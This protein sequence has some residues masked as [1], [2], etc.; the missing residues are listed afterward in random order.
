MN[1]SNLRSTLNSIIGKQAFLKL[2]LIASLAISGLSQAADYPPNIDYGQQGDFV[3]KRGEQ[4]GRTAILMPIGPIMI[5]LPEL[6]GSSLVNVEGANDLIDVARDSAWDLSDL[7]NPQLIRELREPRQVASMPIHAHATVI[8]VDEQRGPLL[9]GR[10]AGDLQFDPSGADSNSQLVRV[11]DFWRWNRTQPIYDPISYTHLTAPYYVRNYW[12]YDLD[13]SGAMAIRDTSRIVADFPA[14]GVLGVSQ[15]HGW[16]GEVLTHWD[17]LGTTSVTG[18]TTW[19]GNLVVVTSD[20]LS[21]GMAIYDVSGFKEGREP[22]LLSVYQPTLSE[23]DGNGG[24]NQIGIGGYWV[25]SYGANK[26]VFSARARDAGPRR[27]NPGMFIVDFTDPTNPQLSCELYFDVDKTDQ[28]DGDGSSDPMYVNFQD[29]YAYVDHFKVD[30]QACESAYVDKHISDA[31]FKQIVYKFDDIA[32][33]CDSS[34]YFRPLGQVGLFGGYDWWQTDDVNEQGMCFF[35]TDDEPDTNAPYVAGHRPLAGQS[36]YPIDGL[37]QIHIPETLRSETLNNAVQLTIAE[38]GEAVNFRLQLSHTGILGVWPDEYLEPNTEYR[39]QV[40]G[41]AD[42]MGNVMTPY[43]F[44]FTTDNGDLFKPTPGA[45]GGAPREV[46]PSYSGVPYFPNQS[47]QMACQPEAENKDLWVVNPDNDS[48]AIF[49]TSLDPNDYSKTHQ[50]RREV[51]LNFEK[52]TSVSKVAGLFAVTHADDDK[53]VFYN[54]DGYPRFTIDTGHGSHPIAS[55]ADG[56]NLYVALYGSGEVAKLHVGRREISQRITVGPTP[57][58]MALFADR[59]LVTRFISTM[60]H[61]EVYDIE[62]GDDMQLSQTIT[63]NKVLV[64]DD[65]VNGSG[66]P[67]YLSSIVINQDGT[68]AWITANKANVDRGLQRSGEP[69][70]EDNTIRP[71]IAILDLT[72]GADANIDPTTTEGSIDLDN[73]ADPSGITL[74]ANPQIQAHTLR[75]NNNLILTNHERNSSAQ[76]TTGSAPQEMC[77]TLRTLYVKNYTDRTVSAIDVASY[78]HSNN[79]TPTIET[80]STVTQEKLSDQELLGLQT[81]YFS[82]IPEMGREGYMT[83]ASCHADGGHDGMTWDITALGEG[84]RNTLSLNGSSGTRFGNLHWS[85]NFDEVQDFEIQM[86]Q[87]NGGDGLIPDITFT[88]GMSPLSHITSGQSEQLDALAAYVNG[89]GKDRVARSPYREY[90][91][92]LSTAAQRGQQ[93]F[94]QQGC[95]DCHS[96][97]AYRDGLS[98]DVGTIKASSGQRLNGTLTVIRTP[99]LIE[100]WMSAPYFHDG[101]A[102]TLQDVLSTGDHY[103]DISESERSDLIEY[104]HSIDR[105]LYIDD[106]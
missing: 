18:F 65:I 93:V 80:L 58:A 22:R 17:H 48:V 26:M 55:V 14:D 3:V 98:H 81:F 88:Q 54:E 106:E 23:P 6:P 91:G 39:V 36:E 31:E 13:T 32:N 10:G 4:Y 2:S 74:L 104:L 21:T 28:S 42:F 83:C 89:L 87:L 72:A 97:Q 9:Y 25:E 92:Q 24:V 105:E 100:L 71:M 77:T 101:S 19:L 63:I 62:I 68:R 49:S 46:A 50:L 99:S 66:V 84:L 90:S 16:L 95:A 33:Q 34:Q 52:P 37:I 45:I 5:N 29:H 86:E 40:S 61:G 53:V 82:S 30:M 69:L 35:V 12:N 85:A 64:R 15:R 102:A 78:M 59:L 20:Q 43:E 96:G 103:V 79:L 8:R 38:T 27:V 56:D 47:S 60:E 41:I 1:I 73:S 70:D 94:N 44:S 75:G 7:T 11:D 51:K 67:N 76:I 57:K